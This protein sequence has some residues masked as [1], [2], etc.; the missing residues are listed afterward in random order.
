MTDVVEIAQSQREQ[1]RGEIAKLDSF[2][3]MANSLTQRSVQAIRAVEEPAPA[4]EDSVEAE[5]ASAGGADDLPAP[6]PWENDHSDSGSADAD[7]DSGGAARRT[8]FRR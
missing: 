6:R 7:E 8:L 4:E 3:R 2:I 5:E 1:L